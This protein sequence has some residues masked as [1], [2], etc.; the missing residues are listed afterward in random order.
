MPESWLAEFFAQHL[1]VDGADVAWSRVAAVLAINRL[2]DPGSELAVEGKLKDRDEN[3]FA[4]GPYPS[5]ASTSGGS[6]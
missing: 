1:D 6:L 4:L 3:A 5:F 2:C